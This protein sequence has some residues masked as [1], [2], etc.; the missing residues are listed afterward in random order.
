M[1]M[2][3][4]PLIMVMIILSLPEAIASVLLMSQFIFIASSNVPADNGENTDNNL[5]QQQ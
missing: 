2:I 5:S 1:M 4:P 3:P